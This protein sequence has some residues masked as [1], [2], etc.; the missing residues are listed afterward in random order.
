MVPAAGDV[1]SPSARSGSAIRPSALAEHRDEPIPQDMQ[2]GPALNAAVTGLHR[3]DRRY[4]AAAANVAS[5]PTSVDDIVSATMT[6]PADFA[7]NA[8]SFRTA[9]EL[10]GTLVDMLG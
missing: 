8:A 9:D 7:A 2:I 1:H 3:A 10:R 4:D 5:D 6:V